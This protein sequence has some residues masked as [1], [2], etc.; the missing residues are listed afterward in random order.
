M[1]KIPS[2]VMK[3][4]AIIRI[5]LLCIVM[6]VPMSPTEAPRKTKIIEKPTT[7]QRLWNKV[8]QKLFLVLDSIAVDP[9][10]LAIYAGTSGKTHGDM[11]DSIPA[12][13]ALKIPISNIYRLCSIAF[14][15]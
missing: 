8:G 15:N 1:R 14:I 12:I 4:P 9:A 7:K 11:K 13:K 5:M 6:V 2:K 10:K 3:I